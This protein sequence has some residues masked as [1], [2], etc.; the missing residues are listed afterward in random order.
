MSKGED[1]P[2]LKLSKVDL[3]LSTKV[4][5]LIVTS[6]SRVYY[7]Y[8]SHDLGVRRVVIYFKCFLVLQKKKFATFFKAR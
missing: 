6:T 5:Y 4:G 7:Y 3:K 1:L 8:Q 2:D